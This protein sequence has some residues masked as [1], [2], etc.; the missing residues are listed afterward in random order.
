VAY[1]LL[2]GVSSVSAASGQKADWLWL[3]G[4]YALFTMA[5]LYILPVG[6]GLFARLAPAA[7]GATAVAAWFFAAFAGNLAS[8]FIGTWWSAMTPAAFF[9]A[10]AGVMAASATALWAI[11]RIARRIGVTGA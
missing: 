10:M 11:A 6:L 2:A 7:L 5:E 4:F 1:V 9:L 8:G 3:A